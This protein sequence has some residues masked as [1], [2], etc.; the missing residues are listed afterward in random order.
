[1]PPHP[2]RPTLF[3]YTTL[4]RSVGVGGPRVIPAGDTGTYSVSLQNLGNVD[5]PYTVFRVGIPEMGVNDMVY[6]LKYLQFTS[7]LRGTP[8]ADGL[9][10]VPWASLDPALNTT[11]TTLA[12]GVLYD[13]A[14]DGFT[15][16]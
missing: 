1:M 12:P 9:A 7:N 4:F 10:D 15:G 5:A 2:P 13:Q 3:P 16:F 11:G 6:G 14:A 8:P